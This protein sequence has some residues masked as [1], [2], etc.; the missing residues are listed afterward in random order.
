MRELPDH[1]LRNR[2]AWNRLAPTLE[3]EGRRKWAQEEPDWGIWSAPESQL[4]VLTGEL[5][6]L[7]TIELGC[8]T[9]YISAWL[10]R[11]GARPVGIDNSEAQL[12]TAKALQAERGIEFPLLH[13]NAEQVPYPDA[14]FDLAISVEEIWKARKA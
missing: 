3:P 1:V 9:G 4:G 6:G 14:S 12:A 7:D 8:G 13:G 10:A 5:D 2:A 11:R